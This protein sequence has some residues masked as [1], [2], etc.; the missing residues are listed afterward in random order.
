MDSC[1]YDV[2]FDYVNEITVTVGSLSFVVAVTA[3][4]DLFFTQTLFSIEDILFTPDD[5]FLDMRD[6]GSADSDTAMEQNCPYI[7]FDYF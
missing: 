7:V 3:T 6:F 4:T 5:E 1:F 2:S